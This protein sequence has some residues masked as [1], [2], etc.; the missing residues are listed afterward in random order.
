MSNPLREE[1]QIRQQFQMALLGMAVQLPGIFNLIRDLLNQQLNNLY[2]QNAKLQS[3]MGNKVKLDPSA[4]EQESVEQEQPR[5][6][7]PGK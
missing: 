4:P 1:D 3:A 6:P 5:S 2:T 7:K